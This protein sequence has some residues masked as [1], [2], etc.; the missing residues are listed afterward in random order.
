[1]PI[2]TAGAIGGQV[3]TAEAVQQE[4][5]I[6][7]KQILQTAFREVNDSLVDQDRTKEQLAGMNR[8]IDALREYVR[9]AWVRFNE[10]YSSY[11]EV[12]YSQNLLYTAELD[13][14]GV[15]RVLF[16]AY[17]NLYKAMGIGG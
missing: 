11:L 10:G 12:T 17:S 4:L 1:M 2:F 9:L 6:R 8:Q 13:R 14:A 5:V 3:Q 16:Q 15:Q 7:Y